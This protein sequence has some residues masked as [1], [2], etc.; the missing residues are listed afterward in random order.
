MKSNYFII[1]LDFILGIWFHFEVVSRGP[2]VSLL[3]QPCFFFVSFGFSQGVIRSLFSSSGPT[4]PV[5][6]LRSGGHPLATM[7]TKN[8]A[9]HDEPSLLGRRRGGSDP[10]LFVSGSAQVVEAP[11]RTLFSFPFLPPPSPLPLPPP[12]LA[13]IGSGRRCPLIGR[14]ARSRHR[15]GRRSSFAFN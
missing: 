7:M 12:P 14:C 9:A 1:R 13:T 8:C 11:R 6:F 15:S 5:L 4:V 10:S 3:I 2:E